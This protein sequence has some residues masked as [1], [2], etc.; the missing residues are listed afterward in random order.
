M[1]KE[2]FIVKKMEI[3]Y[4]FILQYWSLNSGLDAY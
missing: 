1:S 2:T 3:N 4:L